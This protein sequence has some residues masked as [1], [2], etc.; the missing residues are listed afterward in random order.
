MF[1]HPALYYGLQVTR[2]RF[3][4]EQWVFSSFAE[5]HA[6]ISACLTEYL[7]QHRHDLYLPSEKPLP[8]DSVQLFSALLDQFAPL[9]RNNHRNHHH[10]HPA[11]VTDG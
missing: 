4:Q 3:E 7:F 2:L 1:A 5:L 10:Q 9:K 6:S 11:P 8:E